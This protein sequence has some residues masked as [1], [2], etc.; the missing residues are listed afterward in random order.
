RIKKLVDKHNVKTLV[1]AD[2][3]LKYPEILDA[4]PKD[5]ILGTW[6]YDALDNF[7][8]FINPIKERGFEFMVCPGVLNSTRVMPNFHTALKNIRN[9][10]R[11][12]I[13]AGAIGMLNCVWDDGGFALFNRD[14]YGVAYGAE[15]SWNNN[16]EKVEDFNTRLNLGV[17]GDKFNSL[18]D[19]IFKLLELAELPPTDNM[20]EKILWT[21]TIPERFNQL[22]ISVNDWD[23]IKKI[24]QEANSLILGRANSLYDD[25]FEVYL[26]TAELYEFIAD[27]RINIVEAADSYREAMLNQND[28]I[29]SRKYLLNAANNI[30]ELL[31][32]QNKILYDYKRFWLLENK[33]YAL[34][35]VTDKMEDQY[36]KLEKLSNRLLESL[37]D[38]DKRLYLKPPDDIG[39]DI[40][41]IS[42][43]Y[44]RGWLV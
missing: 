13:K 16:E 37:H 21:N 34:D 23:E 44:F 35:R 27:L 39:L 2:E 8:E 29:I 43:Q 17:Y 25:D 31:I 14:W 7:D 6:T 5:I 20:N 28:R 42:G 36:S 4:L 19:A 15:Q 40:K 9:F 18:T 38:F 30:D 1:W 33:T 11:D 32:R 41:K 26:F 3:P 24:S 10:D 22:S 12:A